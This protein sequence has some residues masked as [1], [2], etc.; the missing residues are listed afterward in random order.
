MA[1]LSVVE[2][3]VLDAKNSC[4]IQS[5]NGSDV[6]SFP[7]DH[8]LRVEYMDY[9]RNHVPVKNVQL[10]EISVFPETDPYRVAFC[11]HVRTFPFDAMH[12]HLVKYLPLETNIVKVLSIL[13]LKP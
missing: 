9:F 11:A 10:H 7:L 2:K 4:G 3:R 5:A 8:P 1:A 12:P 6:R 13:W